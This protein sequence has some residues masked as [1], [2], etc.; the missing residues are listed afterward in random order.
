[1]AERTH[2]TRGWTSALLGAALLVSPVA[3]EVTAEAAPSSSA[4]TTAAPTGAAPTAAAAVTA[5]AQANGRAVKAFE[6]RPFYTRELGLAHPMGATYLDGPRLLAVA[7]GK[8][9]VTAIRLLD[10][11]SEKVV[12]RVRLAVRLT[13]GTLAD[14]GRGRLAALSGRTFVT[15]S[16][17]ARGTVRPARHQITGAS[18]AQVRAMTYD[19]QTRAWLGLDAARSR[20][21]S[22]R[23]K[24]HGMRAVA[25]GKVAGLAGHK[26]AGVGYDPATRRVYV[27]DPAAS[28]LVPVTSTGKQVAPAL[29]ITDLHAASLRSLAFGATADPTDTSKA[30]SLYATDAGAAA[31]LGKVSE[32]SLAPIGQ[33]A[34]AAP[35]TSTATL[36]KKT[37]FS[38]MSPPSPDTSG[39]AYMKDSGHLFI[40]DSEVDEMTIYKNVNMW[41]LSLNGSTVFSTGNTLKFSKEPTGVGYDYQTKRLFVSD[42]DKKRIFTLTAGTDSKFGTA[43]DPTVSSISASAF[44]DTDS[45]DVT[46]D[47]KSGDLFVTD[48]TGLEVWRVARGANDRFDGVAPTGDDVVTHFDVGVYGITDLEGMG[49]SETRDSLFLMDRNF[50]KIVEVTKTGALV[51]TID[52]T[53]IGMN[54]PAAIT[55]APASNDPSRMDLYAT[56]RG[57]DNDNHP[58]EN[59]GAM[60][61][62]SAPNL[63]PTGPQTNQA[64]SVNAGADQT[65][66]LPASATLNGTVTDDN[67][68]NPPATT[69]KLWAK[70]SG[71]GTVTFN[72]AT[73]EDPTA[74]FSA[75]GVY[76]LSLTGDDSALSAADTVTIT[77][78]PSGGTNKAPVVTAPQPQTITLSGAADLAGSVTDDGLP[79]P[80]ATTTITW[81]KVS[82]PGTVTFTNASAA[83]TQARFT[84]TGTYVLALKGDD[85]AL[86]TTAQV[87]VTVNADSGGSGGTN[88][89]GNPGFETALT[90]W[91]ASTGALTRVAV[92]H[93]GGW[94][95]EM[96]NT[97]TS[98]ITCQLNDSPNWVASTTAGGTYTATAWVKGDAAGAGS[99]VRLR[100]REYNSAGTNLGSKE[101]SVVLTTGYQQVVLT[102]TPTAAGSTLDFNVL[103]GSTPAGARCYDVDDISIVVN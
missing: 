29:D 39:I 66:T 68:P 65:V 51:Q 95:G 71:P 50:K 49:Y 80:P 25:S 89:A 8:G 9:R 100:F 16:S 91:K 103:R 22:I 46:F 40:A 56:V 90:G 60:F 59:D 73:L 57:V 36:V 6:K 11:R 13:P 62:M 47:N 85:S 17:T 45:E 81:S 1:M 97:G 72:D 28:R 82:G 74:T 15:W 92:P 3:G 33:A 26:P 5:A 75:A 52:I 35:L 55:I 54:K 99:T 2:R 10:P 76:V 63:G 12:G 83:S 42:D 84:Q 58:D 67:L 86:S 23:A 70:V 48:G 79:N 102:Y 44:G 32:V 20:L 27:A 87:Q 24:G 78:N 37:D 61:E 30:T 53:S 101:A 19:P 34:A 7:Q 64:P 21:V 18:V 96:T 14:N 94:A 69:T 38:K 98:S 4:P 43:D 31:T 41:E 93:T 88:L 77:V